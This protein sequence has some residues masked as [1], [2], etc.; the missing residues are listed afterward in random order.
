MSVAFGRRGGGNAYPPA[1]P[2]SRLAQQ[3]SA[4]MTA[5]APLYEPSPAYT[6]APVYEP[7]AEHPWQAPKETPSLAWLWR[8]LGVIFGLLVLCVIFPPAALIIIP[9]LAIAFTFGGPIISMML[10]FWFCKWVGRQ[11]SDTK[12]GARTVALSLFVGFM[13]LGAVVGAIFLGTA[14]NGL[15]QV[16]SEAMKGWPR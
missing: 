4:S 5:P 6:P 8:T 15:P 13:V 9:L 1:A 11:V 7:S 10:L 2:P 14:M 12:E 16:L 3:R